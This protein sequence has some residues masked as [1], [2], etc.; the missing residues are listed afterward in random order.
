[1][2]TQLSIKEIVKNTPLLLQASQLGDVDTVKKLIP[3]SD[4][5]AEDSYAL[6]A[7]AHNGH[8][9]IVELLIPVSNPKAKNSYALQWA[10]EKGHKEIVELLIPVSDYHIVLQSMYN[11][12]E[13]ATLLQQCIDKHESQLLKDKLYQQLDHISLTRQHSV[14]RKM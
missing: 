5:K 3:L 9:D 14:K 7:A 10:A 11:Y 1:M 2:T 13:D 4:P 6:R 8:K 12:K